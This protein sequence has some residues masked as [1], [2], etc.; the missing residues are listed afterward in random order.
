MFF[1]TIWAIY[2]GNWDKIALSWFMNVECSFDERYAKFY[3]KTIATVVDEKISCDIWLKNKKTSF[4]Q[5]FSCFTW[6]TEAKLRKK[7]SY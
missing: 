4:K 1:E 5:F 7:I 2:F 3:V 6:T